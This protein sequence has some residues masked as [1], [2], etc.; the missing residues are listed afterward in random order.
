[1]EIQGGALLR[2]GPINFL[3]VRSR[4]GGGREDAF[5]VGTMKRS[6]LVIVWA[7]LVAVLP[8]C[9]G[10][11]QPE[12]TL[13]TNMTSDT[14]NH[15]QTPD[16]VETSIGTLE[17]NDGEPLPETAEKLYNIGPKAPKGME[18]NRVE[19]VPGKSFFIGFRMY[20]PLEPWINKTWRPSEIELIK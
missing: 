16:V 20:G 15:I 7:G 10:I 18:S 4:G 1:M 17:F 2:K 5:N 11:Q 6:K 9:G 19:S 8:G 3:S 12:A 13:K 14:L